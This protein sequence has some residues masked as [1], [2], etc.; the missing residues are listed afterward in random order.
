MLQSLFRPEFGR[1]VVHICA[2]V[3]GVV[4]AIKVC[5]VFATLVSAY[6]GSAID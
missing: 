1:H 2:T 6:L 5:D 4:V 3:P